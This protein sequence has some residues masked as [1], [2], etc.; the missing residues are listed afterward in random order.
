MS[1]AK[2]NQ[3]SEGLPETIFFVGHARLPENITAKHVYGVFGLELE[4]DPRT[5]VVVDASCT[6]IPS[7]GEKF[8]LDLLIGH[9]LREGIAAPIAEIERRYFGAAQRA[10]ISAL[11]NAYD[12]YLR[13]AESR[14]QRDRLKGDGSLPVK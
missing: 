1:E 10:I 12:R 13:Y 5:D 7:L 4:V 8:L 11:Q 14:S 2:G 9:C 3:F 6:A